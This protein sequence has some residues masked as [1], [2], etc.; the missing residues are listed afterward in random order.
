MLS[1]KKITVIL[2]ALL[3]ICAM[4]TLSFAQT[5]QGTGAKKAV[6][7]T[8]IIRGKI[9]SID[10]AKNE[11]VVKENKTGTE[12]AISI[13]PK[14]IATLK[15]DDQVKVTLKEGSNIAASVKKIVKKTTSTKK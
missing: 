13:D 15:I 7:N 5:S 9:I 12:K 4:S 3:L 8:E 11:I 10:T 6:V 1:M 2:V 14:V